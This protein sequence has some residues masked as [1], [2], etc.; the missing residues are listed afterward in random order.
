MRRKVRSPRT[1][2][3]LYDHRFSRELEVLVFD[4][5]S[6]ALV[7]QGHPLNESTMDQLTLVTAVH[8][9]PEEVGCSPRRSGRLLV[10]LLRK[11]QMCLKAAE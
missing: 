11:G 8:L 7:H 10:E 3:V 5:E 9:S 2:P 4:V 6:S 1:L